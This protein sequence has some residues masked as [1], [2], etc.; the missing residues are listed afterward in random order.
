MGELEAAA[1]ILLT[2]GG[3]AL[4]IIWINALVRWDGKAPPCDKSECD[5]CPFPCEEHNERR[6]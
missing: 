5:T 1:G 2:V 6:P 4:V 3:I